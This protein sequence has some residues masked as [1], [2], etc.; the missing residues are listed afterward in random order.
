MSPLP[1]A[2]LLSGQVSYLMGQNNRQTFR[3]IQIS[4]RHR[5]KHEAFLVRRPAKQL[6]YAHSLEHSRTENI[7]VSPCPRG[8][9]SHLP[10]MC[11]DHIYEHRVIGPQ[12][13]RR[14]VQRRIKVPDLEKLDIGSERS[15][16]SHTDFV[17][18]LI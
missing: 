14:I 18:K 6:S 8:L 10:D 9:R 4:L 17:D 7:A 3:K 5:N 1:I 15:V 2:K 12:L 13:R 11:G 16:Q